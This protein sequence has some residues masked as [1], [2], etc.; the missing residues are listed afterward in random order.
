MN[1][2]K[3]EICVVVVGK[4][5]ELKDSYKSIFES[6]IHAGVHLNCKVIVKWVH[7]NDLENNKI[8]S[9]FKNVLE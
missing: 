8:T 6:L 2:P 5:V 9:Q 4:Y 1:S 3:K 7:S